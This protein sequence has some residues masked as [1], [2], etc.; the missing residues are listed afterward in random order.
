L[1]I[2]LNR[3]SRAASDRL[4]SSLV[5]AVSPPYTGTAHQNVQTTTISKNDSHQQEYDKG[6]CYLIEMCG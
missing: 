5:N 6:G 4:G 3:I 2:A 1:D